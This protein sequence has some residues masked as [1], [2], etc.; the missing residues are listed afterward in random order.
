MQ[1]GAVIQGSYR[2][3][4]TR[5]LRSD[6]PT[7]AFVML[8]PSRAD[9]QQDDPTLR[10]CIGFAQA[11]GFG[12]LKVVN[13]FAY[14]TAQ[15]KQLRQAND[16]VG[17]ENDRYIQAAAEQSDRV[18][19]AWGNQGCWRDRNQAVLTLLN[20]VELYCLGLTQTQQPRHPLYVRGDQC[21]QKYEI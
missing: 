3:C 5:C 8:N 17:Q 1:R 13:L 15:P 19:V 14:R 7:V 4:L 21:L 9:G 11:W 10:R 20:N 6:A 18:V 12:A 16:P 2:Y